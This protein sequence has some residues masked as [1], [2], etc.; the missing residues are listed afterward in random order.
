MFGAKLGWTFWPFLPR[1]PIISC[2]VPSGFSRKRSLE[3]CH[4]HACL[5]PKWSFVMGHPH[6]KLG[7]SSCHQEKQKLLWGSSRNGQMV[8]GQGY[9]LEKGA[10]E[11]LRLIV[12]E[13]SGVAILVAL[14]SP[15]ARNGKKWP[16]N[17][18]W[19]H[20][21]NGGKMAIFDPFFRDSGTTTK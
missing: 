6:Q 4:S 15:S 2:A 18:F 21:E 10:G 13:A 19:P 7:S 5:V 20:R 12:W 1:N 8:T 3:H 17:G 14:Y 16:K 9:H 11:V